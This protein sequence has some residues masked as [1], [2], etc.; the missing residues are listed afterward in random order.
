MKVVSTLEVEE[1]AGR[2]VGNTQRQVD[3]AINE[4]FKGNS[5]LVVDHCRF[6]KANEMLFDKIVR[7]LNMECR[8]ENNQIQV[9]TH[10]GIKTMSL[11]TSV[12][13]RQII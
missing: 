11:I 6:G 5:V 4:L 2:C 9:Q 13:K 10:D 3:F 7:R 8:I 12:L 1:L